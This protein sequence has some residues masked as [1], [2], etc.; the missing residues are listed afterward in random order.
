MNSFNDDTAL[1]VGETAEAEAEGLHMLY[2]ASMAGCCHRH[3]V[4]MSSTAQRLPLA[5]PK[6]WKRITTANSCAP[7]L[8]VFDRPEGLRSGSFSFDSGQ[9]LLHQVVYLLCEQ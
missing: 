7:S 6:A 8:F 1:S 9:I 4:L 2:I 5:V 3:C